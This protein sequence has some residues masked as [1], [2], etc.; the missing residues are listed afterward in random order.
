M[1]IAKNNICWISIDWKLAY[2]YCSSMISCKIL[3]K[4]TICRVRIDTILVHVYRAS[5]MIICLIIGENT[6]GRVRI[7]GMSTNIYGTSVYTTN[8]VWKIAIRRVVIVW[9]L[10]N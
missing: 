8:I 1:I 2:I 10:V 9:I 6:I 3:F 4:G 5:I 7:Y